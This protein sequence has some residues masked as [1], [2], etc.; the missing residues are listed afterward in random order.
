MDTKTA[1][2][3]K[4]KADIDSDVDALKNDISALRDDLRQVVKDVR[5]LASVR[6]QAGVDKGAEIA[7]EA[8]EQIGEAKTAMESRI[9]D[10]PLAAIGIAF[11]AGVVLAMMRRN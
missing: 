10:N 7:K 6:A 5:G 3:T 9:R 1:T 4:I 11:G 8:G 2:G